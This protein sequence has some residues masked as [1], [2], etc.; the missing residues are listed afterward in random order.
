M[1][2]VRSGD[3]R[4]AV[5]ISVA[6]IQDGLHFFTDGTDLIQVASWR[7]DSGKQLLDHTHRISLRQTHRTQEFILVVQGALR[8]RIYTEEDVFQETVDVRAGEGMLFFA[9]GHGY[10]ILDDDTIV[11]E[12]KN[13]PFLGVAEDKRLLDI[14]HKG[15]Q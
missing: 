13:G 10:E 12:V 8:A 5:K 14:K 9:G 2:E 15:G 4:L 3:Q 7:Y 6:E 1:H 11:L